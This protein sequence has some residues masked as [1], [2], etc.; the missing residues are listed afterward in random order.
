MQRSLL[1]L[2]RAPGLGPSHINK[3]IELYGSPENI[4]AALEPELKALGIPDRSVCYLKEPEVKDIEQDL[5]WL[6]Q[7]GHFLVSQADA[8]YPPLLKEISDAPPVLFVSGDRDVLLRPQIAI[9]GSRNPSHMGR[10]TARSFAGHLVNTGLTITSGLALG[11][12]YCAHKGALDAGGHTIAVLGSGPDKV[13]PA[14][15]KS[16]ANEIQVQGAVISEFA[17]GMPPK[18]ENFP[19]RNRIISGMSLGVII[20][21]AAVKS[22]SL[23]TARHAIEQGR[24]VFAVPGSIY[25]P[26]ARGSHYMIKQGA[27][28]I[29]SNED[30]LEELKY[31]FDPVLTGNSAESTWHAPISGLDPDSKLLLECIGYEPISPDRLIE[32]SGLTADAV[33][34]MLSQ[35]EVKGVV[36]SDPCGLY[37][38]TNQ[39]LF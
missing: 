32:L 21:E 23:I 17:T 9:V 36:K 11:I 29:E 26:L 33:S 38:R 2:A 39:R 16:L 5:R 25:N 19:R 3:L 31:R 15:H 7:P 18:P 1:V 6:E 28:L 37:T 20:V 27:K 13:Y 10:Q 12:D 8:C 14:R 24:E 35:L 30:V 22:G 4:L 34:S